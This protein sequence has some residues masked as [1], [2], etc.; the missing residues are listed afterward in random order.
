MTV[1]KLGEPSALSATPGPLEAS[2]DVGVG[3]VATN[4]FKGRELRCKVAGEA[5][6]DFQSR[7]LGVG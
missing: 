7:A 2:L 4:S 3:N 1:R 5:R 6:P